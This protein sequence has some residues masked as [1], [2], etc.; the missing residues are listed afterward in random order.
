MGNHNEEFKKI[1]YSEAQDQY[2]QLNKHFTI[3]EKDTTN[4]NAVEVVFRITHT[5]KANAASMGY[6]GISEMAH[7]LE[8]I[9]SLINTGKITLNTDLFNTLF[10][11]NDK[12]GDLI[13][14]IKTEEKISY[15]GLLTK[16]KDNT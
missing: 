7:I 10:R 14:S 1:F 16:L 15:K 8:D 11:A 3:L 12:I 13:A 9:F 2:E 6:N 4:R 5:L